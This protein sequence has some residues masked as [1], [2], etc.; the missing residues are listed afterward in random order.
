MEN[1]SQHFTE[2]ESYILWRIIDHR[3]GPS[4]HISVSASEEKNN[5]KWNKAFK[6]SAAP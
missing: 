4:L 3:H 1:S 5:K 6:T 2:F